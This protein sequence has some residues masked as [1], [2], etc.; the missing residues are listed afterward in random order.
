MVFDHRSLLMMQDGRWRQ[1]VRS[2][3]CNGMGERAVS[4]P[5]PLGRWE[6][7]VCNEHGA[8]STLVNLESSTMTR[9]DF[10]EDTAYLRAT[11]C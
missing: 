2:L 7:S 5:S 1:T 11:T 8:A 6:G 4:E 3:K 9:P 10:R